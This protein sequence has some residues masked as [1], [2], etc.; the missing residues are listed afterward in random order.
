MFIKLGIDYE[1]ASRLWWES[2]GNDLWEGIAGA[3]DTPHVVLDESL[4]KSWLA[5]AAR[6]PGWEDGPEYAPHPIAKSELED[7]DPD[8]AG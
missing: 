1:H 7:D 5:E 3:P 4:A 2:G 8:V 6:I